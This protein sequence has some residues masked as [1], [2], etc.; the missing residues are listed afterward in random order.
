MDQ[1]WVLK[2][3]PWGILQRGASLWASI[4]TTIVAN[5]AVVSDTSNK[6]E[7]IIGHCLGLHIPHPQV[8]DGDDV[9]RN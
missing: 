8:P 4:I 6:P 2:G 1:T 7:N 9:L 5:I 3:Q